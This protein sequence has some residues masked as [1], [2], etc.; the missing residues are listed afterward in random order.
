VG[1]LAQQP[2]GPN[3]NKYW[4]SVKHV[5][6]KATGDHFFTALVLQ[7]RHTMGYPRIFGP[8]IQY[9]VYFKDGSAKQITRSEMIP[10]TQ[11]VQPTT[12]GANPPLKK[13]GDQFLRTTKDGAKTEAAVLECGWVS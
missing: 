6:M 3:T 9:W 8:I 10:I 5:Q 7:A 12:C 4:D 11:K 13:E 1:V 2:Q